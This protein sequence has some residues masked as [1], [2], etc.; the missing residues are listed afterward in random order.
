MP[1]CSAG[2]GAALTPLRDGSMLCEPMD[3]NERHFGNRKVLHTFAATR[4]QR[5]FAAF[6]RRVGPAIEWRLPAGVRIAEAFAATG[7]RRT[8]V[9]SGT[10][11]RLRAHPPGELD[12][13]ACGTFGGGKLT[14]AFDC[15]GNVS[16]RAVKCTLFD[17]D[18]SVCQGICTGGASRLP[19]LPP[20]LFLCIFLHLPI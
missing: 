2:A 11:R 1:D 17:G 4:S 5:H 19:E 15:D 8:N 18:K 3:G 10:H 14:V 12:S 20:G 7:R 16:R 6:Q 9:S 13:D